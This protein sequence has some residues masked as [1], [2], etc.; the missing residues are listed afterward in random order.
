MFKE[1]E[2][3]YMQPLMERFGLCY[4]GCCE[5]L[6]DR[7]ALL[8][9]IPNMRKLGVTPWA[10]IR[11]SAEQIGKDYVFAFKP[12]PALVGGTLDEEAIRR[13]TIETVEACLTFGCPYELVLKDISTVSYK[14]QNLIRWVQ[15]VESVLDM[16]Y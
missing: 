1:F 9:S 12:N 14:P 11:S 10:D 13:E 7:L 16:Y 6:D 5:P 15:I 4:Y 2:L 3:D 8:K